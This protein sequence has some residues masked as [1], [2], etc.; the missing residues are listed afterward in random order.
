MQKS[1]SHDVIV[2]L[3]I[4]I[5]DAAQVSLSLSQ[6]SRHN[7][8]FETFSRFLSCCW[9]LRQVTSRTFMF[10]CGGSGYGNKDAK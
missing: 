9:K 4:R 10:H 7:L 6:H 3:Q 1:N 8:E 5:L 2:M